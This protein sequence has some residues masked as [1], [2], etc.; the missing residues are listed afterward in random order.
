MIAGWR[1]GK[2]PDRQMK[3]WQVDQKIPLLM[4]VEKKGK[5]KYIDYYNIVGPM[6]AREDVLSIDLTDLKADTVK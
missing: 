4:Y 3:S 6:A 1:T 2:I 5:W